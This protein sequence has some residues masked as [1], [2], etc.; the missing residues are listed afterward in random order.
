MST[1]VTLQLN[2]INV[3]GDWATRPAGSART[4][5]GRLGGETVRVARPSR[6]SD[7]LAIHLFGLRGA[8]EA[9]RR[10]THSPTLADSRTGDDDVAFGTPALYRGMWFA[11]GNA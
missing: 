2:A 9:V 5:T 7:E 11:I 10:G 8:I 1:T 4:G 3:A 6:V